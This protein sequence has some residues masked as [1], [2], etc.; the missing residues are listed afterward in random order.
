MSG[1]RHTPGPWAVEWDEEDRFG[2]QGS[3][4]MWVATITLHSE[5]PQK[6]NARLIA[7]APN[8]LA[9]CE[10]ALDELAGY[11]D[12]IDGPDG[13]RPNRAMHAANLLREAVE[14]ATGGAS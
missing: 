6:A 14:R 8:L 2:L 13:P 1:L 4:T 9:A 5:T 3:D 7:A 12:V 10:A 11:E